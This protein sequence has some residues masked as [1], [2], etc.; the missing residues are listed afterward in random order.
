MPTPTRKPIRTLIL[1]G[2]AD[3]SALA[4]ALHGDPRFEATLSLAG[5]TSAP[6]LPRIAVRSGGFGG[7][8]GLA[9]YLR[10][11]RIDAVIDATHPFASRISAHAVASCATEHVPLLRIARPPWSLAGEDR[12]TEVQDMEA[13]ARA[14]GRRPLRVLLTIGR[15]DLAQFASQP[16]HFYVIRS[17][18]PPPDD[19]L[20]KRCRVIPARGPFR[21]EDERRLFVTHRIQ[22][23]VTKNSGGD[24]AS[25]KLAAA[26]EGPFPV[27]FVARP[28][29]PDG[30][31]VPDW[32]CALAWLQR[33]HQDAGTLR[34]V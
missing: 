7:V 14:L 28:P 9:A 26:K 18:E 30:D 20:P 2:T 5:V 15:R 8:D 19:V 24:A 10:E 11:N 23:L 12:W 1:G 27:I 33:T 4:D 16:Q 34:A 3:A 31:S 13:A 22:V 21:L 17:V 25:A 32:K 29:E 6:L